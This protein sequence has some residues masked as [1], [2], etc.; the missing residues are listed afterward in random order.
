MKR[1]ER[2]D[3]RRSRRDT[4][5]R[6]RILGDRRVLAVKSQAVV[7]V[8]VLALA[9][10][11]LVA[12]G[13]AETTA[14]PTPPPV[15][16]LPTETATPLPTAEPTHTLVPTFTPLP[17]H[18]PTQ[19]PTP[20]QTG[21]PTRTPT[22]SI[23]PTPSNT[24]YPT[25]VMTPATAVPTPVDPFTTTARITNILLL[26]NDV[27]FAQGGRTDT[28]ILLSLNRDTNTASLLSIP[29]DLYVYIPGWR[30]NRINTAFP[31]GYGMDYPGG[32]FGLIKDTF[33]YNF[34]LEVDHYVRIGFDGFK[35][36][37][38]VMGGVEIVNNCP[39]TDWRLID[40]EL[41]PQVEEHWELVTLE[42]S[43][44]EMDGDLALW[45]VRSRRGSSDF[46]RNRRQQQVL[47]AMLNQGVSLDL[48]SRLPSLWETYRG[49]IETDLSLAQMADL[50]RLAPTVRDNGIQHLNLGLGGAVR[51]W[52]EPESGSAVQLLQWETAEPILAQT[53]RPPALNRATRPAITVEVVSNDYILYRQAAENLAWYGFVPVL[54]YQEGPSPQFTQI[55]YYAP[56][57]KGSYDP[58]LRYALKQ[59]RTTVE[60]APVAESNYNFRVVLGHNFDP[61]R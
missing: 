44:Y 58:L 30:M 61:C 40:P 51:S 49:H 22:P 34:G 42:P 29:R 24:P 54:N 32:G 35:E 17:T 13:E 59:E 31:R 47:R 28:M 9:L 43:V 50:A 15:A 3:T 39:I 14:D 36:A 20:T 45:Y 55:T 46:E 57:F 18:T 6:K 23:T 27:P 19:T 11:L 12:C 38:D 5:R 16:Q 25:L 21:T 37:V 10:L 53:M 33:R 60:L 41:D 48:L 4:R 56:N 26:G 52:R 1:V 7:A 2:G 8:A